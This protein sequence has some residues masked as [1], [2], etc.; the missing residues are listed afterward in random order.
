MERRDSWR[1]LLAG[2]IAVLAVALGV[3]IALPRRADAQAGATATTS[4]HPDISGFW[5]QRA[6]LAGRGRG[7]PPQ[8]TAAATQRA[9]ARR[10]AMLNGTD[11][12]V[13]QVARWC[14]ALAF[15]FYLTSSPPWDIII[16]PTDIMIL[17]ERQEGSRHIFMDGRSH[18]DAA[19]LVPTANGDSIGHW[20]GDTLVVDTVGLKGGVDTTGTLRGPN[21]HFVERYRLL[22]KD[23]LSVSLTTEDPEVY[24]QPYTTERTYYR[25]APGIYAMEDWCDA[26]DESQW[27]SDAEPITVPK[28]AVAK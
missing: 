8:M 23:R 16:G 24:A 21:Q 22:D 9:Q 27:H 14:R 20:E 25:S 3:S 4:P 2:T 17:S 28:K 12:G 15:P 6:N 7:T 10:Q 13:T 1:R 19:H 5:E 18:P 26:S 11:T